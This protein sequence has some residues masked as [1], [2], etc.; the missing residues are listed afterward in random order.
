MLCPI[1]KGTPPDLTDSDEIIANTEL[2]WSCLYKRYDSHVPCQ[3]HYLER[4]A[5]CVTKVPPEVM[6]QL[7]IL[8]W[9][10]QTGFVAGRVMGWNIL[11]FVDVLHYSRAQHPDGGH[12]FRLPKS[13]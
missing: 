12:T 5:E 4:L 3:R 10:D 8:T 13:V 7:D 6:A 1:I 9:C 11:K 2:F